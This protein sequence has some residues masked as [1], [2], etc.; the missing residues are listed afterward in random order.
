MD[1]IGWIL[2]A[3]A[4]G[5]WTWAFLAGEIRYERPA[6]ALRRDR[7]IRGPRS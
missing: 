2:P 3:G 7:D 5:Y 4:L 1:W 6:R